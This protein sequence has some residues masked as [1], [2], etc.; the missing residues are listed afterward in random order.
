MPLSCVHCCLF[1]V[2]FKS[3]M[4]CLRAET[5]LHFFAIDLNCYFI[6]TA[7]NANKRKLV[8]KYCVRVGTVVHTQVLNFNML[9]NQ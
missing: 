8:G 3:D 2:H 1:L 9:K 4:I 7:T 5:F 6:Y